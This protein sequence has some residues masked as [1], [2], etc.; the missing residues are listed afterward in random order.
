MPPSPILRSTRYSPT[1]IPSGRSP[2]PAAPPRR[3]SIV[4]SCVPPSLLAIKR[5]GLAPPTSRDHDTREQQQ[6]GNAVGHVGAADRA[7]AA[8]PAA[9][10]AALAAAAGAGRSGRPRAAAA[11][12]GAAAAPAAPADAAP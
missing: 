10:A 8:A 1:S 11:R 3:R 6:R 4:G 12:S 9:L 5:G 2:G 7:A